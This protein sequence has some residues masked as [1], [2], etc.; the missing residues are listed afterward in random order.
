VPTRDATA[1]FFGELGRRGREPFLAKA[2]G[3][4]RFD[5]ST[6]PRI[7]H[8]L[9]SVEQGEV[10]VS[11]EHAD[12]DCVVAGDR[13]VFDAVVSGKANPMAALLRGALTV[14]GR[15]ELFILFQRLLPGPPQATRKQA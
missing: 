8:W 13:S 15:A 10:A 5:V 14:A 6:G 1:E 4:L 2:T 3:I 12:A 9:V 7:E 11:R